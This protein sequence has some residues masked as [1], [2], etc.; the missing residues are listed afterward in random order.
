MTLQELLIESVLEEKYGNSEGLVEL[1]NKLDEIKK[2]FNE[3]VKKLELDKVKK[4]INTFLN[5]YIKLDVS[6]M[7]IS[8]ILAFINKIK[9]FLEKKIN[10]YFSLKVI[11]LDRIEK[12][13]TMLNKLIKY[14]EDIEK[15]EKLKYAGGE[16]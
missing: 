16:I 15:R 9:K 7:K 5:N 11:E 4:I 8:D 13:I 2:Y 3:D 14:L 1:L 6:K 10:D 12:L